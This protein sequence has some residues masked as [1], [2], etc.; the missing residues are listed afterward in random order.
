MPKSEQTY[1]RAL[2]CV[3][4]IFG[5]CGRSPLAFTGEGGESLVMISA[6]SRCL[7]SRRL[8]RVGVDGKSDRLSYLT[9]GFLGGSSKEV[10]DVVDHG[11][12]SLETYKRCSR[13]YIPQQYQTF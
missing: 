3:P 6:L 9:F 5:C 13:E 4:G 8:S 10:V 2:G 7:A 11:R 1:F 12:S